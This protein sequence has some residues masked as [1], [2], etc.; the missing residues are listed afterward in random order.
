VSIALGEDQDALAR[1]VRRWCDAAVER[2]ARRDGLDGPAEGEEAR[3]K[4]MVAMGWPSLHLPE[5]HGGQ[6][7]GLPELAVVL[8][9]LGR[10]GI[11]GP[12][13][14]TAIAGAV[15]D[16]VGDDGARAALLPGLAAGGTGAVAFSSPPLALDGGVVRGRA[17]AVLGAPGAA[18]VVLPVP[19]GWAV[20]DGDDVEVTPATG[21]DLLRPVG[22]VAVDAEPLAVLAGGDE[23]AGLAALVLSAEAVG[24]A[25]WCVDTAA[26]Y[27]R[28]RVQ[29]G[30]PIGQFQG[31]KHRCADMLA[32]LELAR[33][34]VWD[35]CRNGEALPVACAAALAPAAAVSI[36]KDCIQ[37][38]GGIGFTWE[39]D[40]HLYLRR[41]LATRA[42]VPPASAWR[43]AAVAAVRAGVAPAVDVELPAEAEA[44]RAEVAAWV[45]DLVQQPKETWNE[46][47]AGDGYL[48]AHWPPPW[49]RG[50]GPVEQL[51]IDQ[52][53][54]RARV[55]R[56]HLQ[57]AA[58]A[59]PTLIAHGT[60]EQQERWM[61][62]S[63]RFEVRWCQLFS[64]PE[65]GS[66]LASLRTRATRTTG[67]WLLNGQKVWTSMAEHADWG[68][69][70]A[71]TSPDKPPHEGITCF[72]VD[73]KAPGIE[74]RP[75]RELTGEA[76]FNE[77][78]FD[79]VFVPDDCV[80]GAVDDGWRAGRTTLANERVAMGSGASLGGG[81]L[82]L[83][84]LL[85]GGAGPTAVDRVGALV[86]ADHG[87]AA[88]RTR[89][90]LR[91]LDGADAGPE[92][93]VVKLLGVLHDQDVQEAGLELLGPAAATADG[94]AA[95]WV[96]SFLWN[97][98]L[99][100]AGGTSEIQRNV[101]AERL[102][103]L[104]RD[105]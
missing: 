36:A 75:L 53:L 105:P 60:P 51:V 18:L 43:A 8:E 1:T 76:W 86:A 96:R 48:V 49:G 40:A 95:G 46:R 87:L 63:L 44:Y 88:L 68:I 52:E 102:L 70:L 101:I 16:R 54:R 4:E 15:V 98:C 74:I 85:D 12:L 29:F 57:V 80:I 72:F 39:H 55:S 84:A 35:A 13:V 38:L 24:L 2:G 61:G 65:A 99:T 11:G 81:V 41:A 26:A 97:R 64:E 25:A 33:A 37:V 100:I 62:P 79:D 59:L 30:R 6:G 34:A 10:A 71:R 42:L 66:D 103:G 19:G 94:E 23:V 27:A 104:P 17:E 58:W 3:W 67:G 5:A 32:N 77:V 93:S 31:V 82:A 92:A 9:E 20:V 89:M 50:A 28:E 21:V 56:P 73:M 14:P 22:A 91:A 7:Y 83:A 45:D 90:T 78:F 69:C 47:L